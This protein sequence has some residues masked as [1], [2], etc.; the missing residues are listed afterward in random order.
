VAL[1]LARR[2][3]LSNVGV[4]V[5]TYHLYAGV[6]K[7]EDVAQLREDSWRLFFVHVSDVAASKPR[8]LWTVPDRV[9]PGGPG[10]GGIPNTQL[11]AALQ[12][13][14]YTGDVSLELFA[15]D[16]EAQWTADPVAA[17]RLAYQRCATLLPDGWAAHRAEDE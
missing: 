2:T 17:A 7:T 3:G 16:F 12:P 8:E 9:L 13:L 4:I 14:S 15:A 11:L 5:D 1:A 10:G 6:S